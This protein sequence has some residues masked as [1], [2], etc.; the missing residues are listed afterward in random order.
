MTT[1]TVVPPSRDETR[2]LYTAV[3]HPALRERGVAVGAI[4]R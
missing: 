4:R 1:G 2:P 3:S